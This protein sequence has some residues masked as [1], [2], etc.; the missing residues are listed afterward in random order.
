MCTVQETRGPPLR[1]LS[2]FAFLGLSIPSHQEGD[3]K[4]AVRVEGILSSWRREGEGRLAVVAGGG[5]LWG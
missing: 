5:E 2:G 1:R 3:L 4:T